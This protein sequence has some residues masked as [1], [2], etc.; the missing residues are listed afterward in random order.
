MLSGPDGAGAELAAV[1][2]TTPDAAGKAIRDHL[3]EGYRI[4]DPET[5]F[6][7]FA[8]RLHQ[9]IS[10]GET[11]YSTIEE[12]S[13]RYLTTAAQRFVPGDR[14]KILFRECGQDY[15]PVWL[16]DLANERTVTERDVFE[17]QSDRGVTAGFIFVDGQGNSW[18]SDPEEVVNRLPD[19]WL[20]AHDGATRAKKD[21]AKNLP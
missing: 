13:E 21:V 16:N 11:V 9:F 8:F 10:R 20:E 19:D 7:A 2:D 18:P 4:T 17:V 3:L 12:P 6:R 15:Y 1:A 5:G 14:S